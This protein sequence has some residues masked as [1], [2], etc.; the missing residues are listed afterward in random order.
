MGRSSLSDVEGSIIDPAQPWNYDLIFDRL[1]V[2][3]SGNTRD[4]TIRCQSTSIPGTQHEAVEVE[5][6]GLKLRYRGRKTYSGNFEVTFAENVDWSTYEIFR[7]WNRL[8][9]S[10]QAN[11]GASSQIYKVPATIVVFDDAGA[12]VREYKVRGVWPENLN[13]ITLD[14]SQSGYVQPQVTFSFD[15]LDE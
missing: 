15:Y 7:E 12:I 10:W 6:H 3:T 14:G 13:D 4:L 9:L 5:L 2:G 11:T 1:P 8:M